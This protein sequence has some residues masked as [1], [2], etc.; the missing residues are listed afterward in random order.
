M[1]I[2]L[3]ISKKLTANNIL[4]IFFGGNMEKR[5]NYID[6]LRLILVFLIIIYHIAMAFNT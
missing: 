2:F 5:Y 6:N 4:M 1:S 3:K